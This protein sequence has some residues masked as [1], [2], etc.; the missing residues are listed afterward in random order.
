MAE[1]G[2]TG[3]A[4]KKAHMLR[5]ILPPSNY[6]G[7]IYLISIREKFFNTI[8]GVQ[9]AGILADQAKVLNIFADCTL[10]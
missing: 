9:V 3:Q 1:D 7:I 6:Y 8:V 4:Y 2:P 10:P 5:S